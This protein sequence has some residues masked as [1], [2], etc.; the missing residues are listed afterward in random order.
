MD[1][2]DVQ[3]LLI[4]MQGEGGAFLAGKRSWT[5]KQFWHFA[6]TLYFSA[7]LADQWRFA[8]Q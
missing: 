7:V 6:H 3:T 1:S 2:R 4:Q 5:I 8:G